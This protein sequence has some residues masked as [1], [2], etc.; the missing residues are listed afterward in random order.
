MA[1]QT[2]AAVDF[3]RAIQQAE[4]YFDLPG[5]GTV[6]LRSLSTKDAQS[7]YQQ[8]GDNRTDLVVAVIAAGLVEPALTEEQIAALYDAKSGPVVAL[9]E[10]IGEISAINPTE[11]LADL[12]G[13]GSST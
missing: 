12:A 10:R 5:V 8:H 4:E 9:F 1:K 3:L 13:G 7:I 6:K 11:E 2:V